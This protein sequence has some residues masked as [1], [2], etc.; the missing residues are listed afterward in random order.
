MK[1][2]DKHKSP[3]L[4]RLPTSPHPWRR[5]LRCRSALWPAPGHRW[6]HRL[7]PKRGLL[8]G[9][10]NHGFHQK[11]RNFTVSP[12]KFGDWRCGN[13]PNFAKKNDDLT[14][15]KKV[16][17]NVGI[18]LIKPGSCRELHR[19]P[20][21]GWFKIINFTSENADF[22]DENWIWLSE[23]MALVDACFVVHVWPNHWG[24]SC[25]QLSPCLGALAPLP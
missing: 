15:K 14:D 11:I 23:T 1:I 17:P 7:D 25:P 22:T 18:N 24:L 19:Q 9:S 5:A 10:K 20:G 8:G 2:P 4:P 6:R 13:P 3:N 12:L 21:K 16:W